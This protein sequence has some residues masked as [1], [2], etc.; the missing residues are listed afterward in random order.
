MS[1]DQRDHDRQMR[2]RPSGPANKGMM[3]LS[4]RDITDDETLRFL[5]MGGVMVA[6]DAND[7]AVLVD[8]P[9]HWTL[10]IVAAPRPD[11]Q[12]DETA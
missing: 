10:S 3:Q 9:P 7:R 6:L 8:V 4:A 11:S 2:E 12:G 1:G 5:D